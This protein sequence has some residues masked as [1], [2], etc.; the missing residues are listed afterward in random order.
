MFP[1]AMPGGIKGWLESLDVG[2]TG[3]RIDVSA[4]ACLTFRAPHE[5]PG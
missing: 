5:A 4:A 3:T 1:R 2:R